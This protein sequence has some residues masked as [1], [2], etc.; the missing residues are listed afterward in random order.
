VAAQRVTRGK[1]DEPAFLRL[2][3]DVKGDAGPSAN[4]IEEQLAVA[5]FADRAGRHRA[6]SLHL[7]G[8]DDVAKT[9]EGGK[10][11]VGGLRPD[12]TA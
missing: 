12:H 8:V 9:F 6:D 5:R 10:R 4:A 1:I 2:V 3:D 11:G 7:V